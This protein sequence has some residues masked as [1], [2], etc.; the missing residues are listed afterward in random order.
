MERSSKSARSTHVATISGHRAGIGDTVVTALGGKP[1]PS[2][3]D[4]TWLA[5]GG[6]TI[7]AGVATAIGGIVLAA[8]NHK[9]TVTQS[10]TLSDREVARRTPTWREVPASPMSVASPMVLPLWSGTF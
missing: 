1:Q 8:T 7:A 4:T 6:V 5:V 10:A 2:T 9:T 3:V